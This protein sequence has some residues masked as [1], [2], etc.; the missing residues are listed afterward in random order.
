MHPVLRSHPLTGRATVFVSPAYVRHV[1]GLPDEESAALL[2]D[3][4]AHLFQLRH[5]YRHSW[6]PDD[7]LVWDNGRLL[8]KATTLEMPPESERVMWRVQTL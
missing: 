7:L 6:L 5:I 4:Y 2:S 1:V 3:L 8:H